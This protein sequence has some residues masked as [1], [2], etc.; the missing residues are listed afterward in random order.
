M[1]PGKTMERSERMKSVER[2]Y[3]VAE[4]ALAALVE[5]L[6]QHSGLLTAKNLNVVEWFFNLMKHWRAIASGYD[7]HAAVYRGGIIQAAFVDWLK[8]LRDTS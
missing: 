5:A 2:E 6:T 4:M 8:H 1:K 3:D 7:K